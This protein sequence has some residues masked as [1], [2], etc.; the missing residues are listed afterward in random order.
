L[1]ILNNLENLYRKQEKLKK[2][3]MMY[4]QALAGREKALGPDH[5]SILDTVHNLGLLYSDQ[6][7]LKEPY[8]PNS[9]KTK[10]VADTLRKP[11]MQRRHLIARLLHRK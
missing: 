4:Q 7:K 5:I 10:D 8:G 3:E 9:Y 11:N 6:G 1:C 2:V